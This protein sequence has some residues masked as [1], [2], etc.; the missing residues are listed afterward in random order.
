VAIGRVNT[1]DSYNNGL[2]LRTLFAGWPRENLAQIYSSGDTGDTG[3]FGRYYKL[4]ERDRRLGRLFYRLK[5]KELDKKLTDTQNA[6]AVQTDRVATDSLA[7]RLLVNTGLYELIFSP[8]VSPQMLAWVQEFRP[9]VI[10]AQGYSLTFAMLPIKLRNKIP[11]KLAFFCSD[12]WPMYLYAGLMD[13]PRLL[14]CLIRPILRKAVARLIAATDIPLAFGHPMAMEYAARYGK[15]FAVLSHADSPRRFEVAKPV[16]VHPAGTF[17]IMAVGN[18]N[19]F[20]WPL[21]LDADQS[22]RRLNH[23]GISVRVAVLVSSIEPEGARRLAGAAYIDILADPGNDRLPCYLKGADLLFLAEGFDKGFVSAI[24]LSISSKA[25][26]FMFSQRPILVYAGSDT[27]IAGYA[28]TYRWARVVSQRDT[29]ALTLAIRD[30]LTDAQAAGE[31]ISQANETAHAFHS[32]CANQKRFFEA[33]IGA[34]TV[35]NQS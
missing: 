21:L 5:S 17:T 6:H 24:R 12:D 9:D 19:R 8:C 13:E 29:A 3:F 22:C 11:M 7:R 27:G 20:R 16:R 2:L 28:T 35:D 15:H 30:L 34:A 14:C 10:F 25:H 4:G 26:L 18:F 31:L 33:M 23:Q 32:R 1:S